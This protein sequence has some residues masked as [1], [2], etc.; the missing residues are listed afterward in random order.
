MDVVRTLES[1][2]NK[3]GKPGATAVIDSAGELPP[4]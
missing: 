1:K 4:V 3:S 2:G